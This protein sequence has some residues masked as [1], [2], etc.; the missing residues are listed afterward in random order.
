MIEEEDQLPDAPADETVTEPTQEASPYAPDPLPAPPTQAVSQPAAPVSDNPFA[1]FN[2]SK[3]DELNPFSQFNTSK[4]DDESSASGAFA[5]G[6]EKGI[7]PTATALPAIGFGATLGAELGAAGGPLASVAGGFVG[8]LVGGAAGGM[9]GSAVQDFALSY[10]PDDIKKKMG[11]DEDQAIIDEARH[12]Y[13]AQIGGLVP[14]LVTARPWAAPGG[15]P[16]AATISKRVGSDLLQRGFSGTVMGG[17]EFGN[18]AYHG[19]VDWNKVAIATAFGTMFPHQNKYGTAVIETGSNGARYTLGQARDLGIFGPGHNED[20]FQGDAEANQVAKEASHQYARDEEAEVQGPRLPGPEQVTDTARKMEPEL[21]DEYDR[22]TA[23]KDEARAAIDEINNGS[24]K[25]V[26]ELTKELVQ[27]QRDYSEFVKGRNGYEGGRE[28]RVMRQSIRAIQNEISSLE[29][30]PMEAAETEG[31]DNDLTARHR[32]ELV[33][34]DEALRDLAP[35]LTEAKRRAAIGIGRGDFVMEPKPAEAATGEAAQPDYT[36]DRKAIAAEATKRALEAGR[37]EEEAKAYGEL[38]ASRYISRASRFEG[39]LGSPLELYHAEG[40]QIRSWEPAKKVEPGQ[41]PAAPVT[42]ENA[43]Q[44]PAEVTGEVSFAPEAGAQPAPEAT[45]AP[46]AEPPAP[47][48]AGPKAGDTITLNDTRYKIE[49]IDDN[50]VKLVAARKKDKALPLNLR[51]NVFD[52]ML[53]EHVAPAA[54]A[55]GEKITINGEPID[56]KLAEVVRGLM[57]KQEGAPKETVP[58]RL[59]EAP[60]MAAL[61]EKMR[62]EAMSDEYPV[63]QEVAPDMGSEWQRFA[64]NAQ[65]AGQS[66]GFVKWDRL[67]SG[68]PNRARAKKDW[69]P[70]NIVDVGFVKDLLVVSKNEDGSFTLLGKPDS[71]GESQR[72]IS[73]PHKGVSKEGKVDFLSA[74]ENLREP[75]P[76]AQPDEP[77]PIVQRVTTANGTAVDVKPMVVEAADLL[78]SSDAGY[79]KALQPRNRDRAASQGQIRDIATRL[80]P[81]RLGSSSEAD[82][83]APIVGPDNMVE[84]GNGRVMAIREAYRQ[85][86]QAAQR[87]RD[88]IASQGID[89]SKYKEP[90]LIRQRV[91]EMTP[92]QR[93]A[94]TVEANQSATLAMSASERAM[95]D[96]RMLTP[97]TLDLVQNPDDLGAIKNRGFVQAFVKGLPQSEQGMMTTAEGG[98][99]SEGLARVRNAVLAKA[100]GDASLMARI[101]EATSD[102]VKSISN[103]LTSAAPKWAKLRADVEAGLVRADMDLT[104]ELMEAVKRTADL[105]SKGVKLDSFLA[106]QDAFDRLNPTVEAWMRMF[107]NATGRRAASA[108]DIA[109]RVNF[110]AQEARKVSAQEGLAFDLTPVRSED[111][112]ALAAQKGKENGGSTDQANLFEPRSA[113][114]GSRNEAGGT[115]AGRQGAG[116]VGGGPGEPGAGQPE[117]GRGNGEVFEQRRGNEERLGAYNTRTREIWLGK[118]ADPSSIIHESG[119]QYLEELTRDAAHGEAPAQVKADLETVKDWV[120]WKRGQAEFTRKQHEKFAKGFERYIYDGVAPSKELASVFERFTNWLREVYQSIRGLK[121]NGIPELT[122]EIRSVFDRLLSAEPR[123]TVVAGEIKTSRSLGAVHEAEAVKTTHREAGAKAD[124]ADNE[125]AQFVKELPAE[126]KNELAAAAERNGRSVRE[127]GGSD[128]DGR[129]M[130]EDRGGQGARAGSG[131]GGQSGGAQRGGNGENAAEGFGAS[132]GNDG[133]GYVPRERASFASKE[134]KFVDKAGNIRLENITNEEDLREAAR[135]VAAQND[136]FIGDR[137]GV[138]TD[139]QVH[140]LATAIGDEGAWRMVDKWAKGSAYNAEEI[141]AMRLLFQKQLA[142]VVELAK[143]AKAAGEGDW[144]AMRDYA[145]ERDRL[146]NIQKTVSGATAEWGRAGRSF[147]DISG[148][149]DYKAVNKLFQ[150]NTGR[151]LFQTR[152]ELDLLSKLDDPEAAANFLRNSDRPGFHRYILEYWINNLIS[153]PVTHATYMVGNDLLAMYRAIPETVARAAVGKAM[154]AAGRKTEAADMVHFGEVMAQVKGFGEGFAPALKAAAGSFRTGVTTLL[155]GETMRNL[156]GLMPGQQFA[157][158]DR[159][160]PTY[161]LSRVMPDMF[162]AIRGMKDAVIAYGQLLDKG[163]DGAPL[164]SLYTSPL[165]VIPDIAYKGVPVVPFGSAIRVPGRF[166]QAIHAFHRVNFYAMEL[167]AEA[168]RRA[169][170]EGLTG[171]A[172][173]QRVAELKKNPDLEMIKRAGEAATEGTMMGQGGEFTRNLARL[174]NTKVLGVPWLKFIDPFVHITGNVIEQSLGQRTP[175]ALFSPDMRA[176]LSGKNGTYA[177]DKAMGRIMLGTAVSAAVAGYV[178]EGSITGGGPKDREE[179]GNWERLGIQPYSVKIG[180]TWYSYH[181]LGALGLLIGVAADMYKVAEKAT[182]EEMAEAGAALLEAFSHNI[183][184][185]SFMRGPSELF[186]AIEN[187]KQYGASWARNFLSS[188][189]PASV[190]MSQITR[191]TDPYSRQARTIMDAFKSKYPWSAGDLAPRRDLWGEPIANKQL[192]AG[193]AIY[194]SPENNDPVNREMYRLNV[195]KSP[196]DKKIRNVELSPEQ[197]DDYARIAGRLTKMQLDQVINSPDYERMPDFQKMDVI[198]KVFDVT[199]KA[200]RETMLQKYPQLIHDAIT[201]KM[202]RYSDEGLE[203]Q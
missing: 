110:Y 152:V 151:T 19:N 83:G 196:V 114:D 38:T 107:Y 16:M 153:G 79:D 31:A 188:F 71:N 25:R 185:E 53:G 121:R 148:S 104:P 126:V 22:L 167:N 122:P 147:R 139:G 138:V 8:G 159:M 182:K 48:P 132:S 164:W 3:D 180:D 137:R 77:T 145:V 1:E 60:D 131:A 72:Y 55:E 181:R 46:A 27:A 154:Q 166:I 143:A 158:P 24:P 127:L 76:A 32:Q 202:N 12:P 109:E 37:P 172:F 161:K 191:A 36:A 93:K 5:R 67:R 88:W 2:T 163:V 42:T 54:K 13:A 123:R 82:R 85:N 168:Y 20:T 7:V 118:K 17:W 150:E 97:E 149:K 73:E 144:Q 91:T 201:L 189:A 119:H 187:P 198:E 100:Y 101:A 29:N 58:G 96:A 183:L 199:R 136:G 146:V 120:G 47:E 15:A 84:S 59:P 124:R 176:D 74:T 108:A 81:N 165:G 174:T 155:P 102:E 86:G 11:L 190:G 175:L 192:T 4:D 171:D 178:M 197:L 80:D 186:R 44:A 75:A 9:F 184:E 63:A 117:S 39:K 26:G 23:I 62:Q 140:D 92:E 177:Q 34:A 135:E 203:R 179:K 64:A 156:P 173:A 162:G 87:Y 169:S 105:R 45:P 157:K 116:E 125:R 33:K 90:V 94:F 41:L 52:Q 57:E 65:E 70:G 200:A 28:A 95:A 195:R 14:F 6:M 49:A 30:R 35:K 106:Q 51:R 111:V 61:R 134:G 113:G 66:P 130:A 21:F 112:Q 129:G 133:N 141:M 89:V 160:D 103:A 50:S 115:E 142:K 98:L 56:A 69:T 194:Q 68:S 193:T 128:A 10:V 40:S 170:A 43:A 78:T 99:S 18:E